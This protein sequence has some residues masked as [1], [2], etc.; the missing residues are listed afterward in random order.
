M[1]LKSYIWKD[2]GFKDILKMF[3]QNHE[4]KVIQAY[5]YFCCRFCCY[6]SLIKEIGRNMMWQ[7]MV[8]NVNL[9]IKSEG[10]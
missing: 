7:N 2:C 10:R 9:M 5:S 1:L 6:Q 4:V 8:V 3:E